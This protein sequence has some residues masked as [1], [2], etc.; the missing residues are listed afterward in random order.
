MRFDESEI[1]ELAIN[2]NDSKRADNIRAEYLIKAY[3][4]NDLNAIESISDL[5][6]CFSEDALLIKR[7][8]K[9]S[10]LFL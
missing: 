1:E 9:S 8:R 6:D 3:I 10:S 7:N 2:E 5:E 4:K